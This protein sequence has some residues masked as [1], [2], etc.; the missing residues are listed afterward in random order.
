MAGD[1]RDATPRSVKSRALLAYLALSPCGTADRG[2]VAGLLWSE[3]ADA[4]ASLRQGVKELRRIFRDLG[5]DILR[6]DIHQLTLDLQR[7]WVDAL[8]LR[9][10][11][12]GRPI[13]ADAIL[14]LY[15]GDLLDGLDVRDA[16]FE[17]W[18][19]VAR[20]ELRQLVCQYLEAALAQT[21]AAR[22]AKRL[23]RIASGLIGLDPA[24]EEGHRA[25]MRFHALAGDTAAAVRQYNTCKTMLARD[26]DVVPSEETDQLL[27]EIRRGGLQERQIRER[28]AGPLVIGGAAPPA[29]VTVEFW[30][31][32]GADTVDSAMGAFLTV[33][34]RHALARK[35]WLCVLDLPAT[36]ITATVRTGPRGPELS[37]RVALAI[38][39]LG[40]RIRVCVEVIDG[41]TSRVLAAEHHDRGPGDPIP[42]VVDDLA[43]AIAFRLEGELEL[44]EIA[45]VARTP[46]EVQGSRD[47]TLRAIPLMLDLTPESFREAERLLLAAQQA[48]PFDTMAYAWRAFWVSFDIGQG[49]SRDPQAAK[50]EAAFLVRRA[51]ELDPKNA[52]ALAVAGHIASFV[53]HDYER[54][55]GLFERSLQLDPNSAYALDLSALTLCYSGNAPEGLRR[56][57]HLRQLWRTYPH[58]YY[59]RTTTCIALLLS[60]D[61]ERAVAASEATIRENPN[62]HAPYR[63]LIA[64]LGQ[65]GRVMRHASDWLSSD[66]WSPISA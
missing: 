55:L 20:R 8:E 18:L 35:R 31:T 60:G 63:P 51:L 58:S 4:K 62:Y 52:L 44:A 9:P 42:G 32:P 65:L 13:A 64:S 27:Q 46:I 21:W 26:L 5:L 57:E 37:Y 40:E 28:A 14:N 24:H 17:E 48:D 45:R 36:P 43:A 33:A 7:V 16:S 59:F 56:V 3:G 1:G 53:H 47:L 66:S 12:P 23:E 6:V 50:L 61:Y 34:L 11:L 41:A 39:R 2:R 15:A 10:L 54:A 29:C 30:A 49:W 25:L 38:L 19:D 22:D